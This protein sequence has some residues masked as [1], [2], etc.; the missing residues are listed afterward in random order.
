MVKAP[1]RKAGGEGPAWLRPPKLRPSASTGVVLNQGGEI[2]QTGDGTDDE[3][4]AV[5]PS[6][7]MICTVT[8][9]ALTLFVALVE[10][11][12]KMAWIKITIAVIAHARST[13]GVAE[14]RRQ[15]GCGDGVVDGDDDDA[16]EREGDPAHEPAGSRFVTHPLVGVSADWDSCGQGSNPGRSMSW[17]TTVIG[18]ANSSGTWAVQDRAVGGI[19]WRWTRSRRRLGRTYQP[20]SRAILSFW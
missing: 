5:N 11:A 12:T 13:A 8:A 3:Q 10:S 2:E 4:G 6:M 20:R 7:P 18:H 9:T 14:Q 1:S 17:P 19:L 15:N 16:E